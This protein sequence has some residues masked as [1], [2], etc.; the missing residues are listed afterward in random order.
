MKHLFLAATFFFTGIFVNAQP[1]VG[2]KAPDISLPGADGQIIKLSSLRGKVV[3][4]DFW[5]S[6]CG[7]CRRSNHQMTSLYTKY[8][9]KGFE[10]YAV[11]IDASTQAWSQAVEQDKAQW[12]QV[13]DTKAANG[14]ELTRIWNLQYIPS[15][16]IIGKD[17]SIVAAGLEKDDVEKLLKRLL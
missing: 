6:W 13:I 11:S 7:P 4:L 10:V 5:A 12:L 15:N 9:D 3:M 16:F 2:A 14:N 17:G 1:P 8:R